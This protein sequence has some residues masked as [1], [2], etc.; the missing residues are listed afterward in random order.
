VTTGDPKTRARLA[1]L[2]P[3]LFFLVVGALIACALWLDRRFSMPA[4]CPRS[5]RYPLGLP[6]LSLGAYLT[7]RSMVTFFRS[8]G[9]PSPLNPPPELVVSGLYAYL[10][11]PM[12]AGEI[13]IGLALGLVLSSLSLAF[14]FTPIFAILLV[15]EIKLVEEPELERRLGQPYLEYRQRV[16]MFIPKRRRRRG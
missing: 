15:L 11:N 9:T 13:L 5:W 16:R 3:L 10:R 7:G 14:I 12:L 6:L 4:P 2:G 8:Q 1:P